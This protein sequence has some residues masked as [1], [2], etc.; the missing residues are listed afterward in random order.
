LRRELRALLMEL[1]PLERAVLERLL[2]GAHETLG[3]LRKQLETLE[4]TERE[5]TGVGFFTYFSTAPSA[6][7]ANIGVE[8]VIW[9]DVE[10]EIE[11]LQDGAGFLLYIKRGC[12]ATLE[13]Y[14]H[15]DESWPEQIGRFQLRYQESQR[16]LPPELLQ[17]PPVP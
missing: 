5:L 11:G 13:G 2:D 16:I 14:T 8:E 12:L 15:G 17:S 7:A 6:A 3:L 1:L 9:G 4:G 10:A